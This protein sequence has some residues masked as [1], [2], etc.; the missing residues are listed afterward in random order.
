MKTCPVCDSGYPDQHIT[1]PTDGALLLE[2]QEL[3]PGH[4]QAAS[5]AKKACDEGNANGCSN[6]GNLYRNGNGV[7]QDAAKAREYL[8]KGCARGS[9]WG[10]DRLKEMQ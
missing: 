10:C 1:C 6:L 3:A 8:Q 4:F 9:K 5:L 2:S 7:P